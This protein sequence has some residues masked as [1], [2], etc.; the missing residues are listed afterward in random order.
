[1]QETFRKIQTFVDPAPHHVSSE[2][3]GKHQKLG[4]G[5][6]RLGKKGIIGDN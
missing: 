6:E 5:I 4:K 1:M 2:L 3:K